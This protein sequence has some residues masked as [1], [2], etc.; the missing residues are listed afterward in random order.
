M[1]EATI[2]RNRCGSCTLCC[3]LVGVTELGK[4]P[5]RWR[6]DLFDLIRRTPNLFWMLLTKRIGNAAEMLPKDWGEGWP[7]VMIMATTVNQEE[8]DR[9]MPKLLAVPARWRGLSVE[10]MLGYVYL[11]RPHL[12][13]KLAERL[14]LVICGGESGPHARDFDVN[15]GRDLCLDC[16]LSGIAFF[17][18]QLGC[19]PR[20]GATPI[21]LVED[22][23]HGGDMS[24]FPPD[25]QVRQ[26]PKHLEA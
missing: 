14:H 9:D 1:G 5:N 22:W 11:Q 12:P 26:F 6:Q 4:K 19:R 23:R 7:N 16:G 24:E 17:M 18:K 21:R 25:L 8:Y 2:A 20:R 15:W 10:P 13:P 3:K